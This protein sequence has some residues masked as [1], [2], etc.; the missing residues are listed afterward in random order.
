MF[1]IIK[2]YFYLYACK[3][4]YNVIYVFSFCQIKYKQG[5]NYVKRIYDKWFNISDQQYVALPREDKLA[6][7]KNGKVIRWVDPTHSFENIEKNI[8]MLYITSCPN[9]SPHE[10]RLFLSCGEKVRRDMVCENTSYTFISI[11][12][13]LTTGTLNVNLK[14]PDINYYVVGNI[15]NSAFI[16][17]YAVNHGGMDFGAGEED[18][19]YDMQVIDG[20]ACFF[21]ITHKDEIVLLKHDYR[22]QLVSDKR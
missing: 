15:L 2:G 19:E 21:S 7:V 16:K 1:E 12:V 18:L 6:W 9:Q 5:L 4:A 13:T 17:Y 10:N 20:N 3:L 22:V 14:L 11:Q 8:N